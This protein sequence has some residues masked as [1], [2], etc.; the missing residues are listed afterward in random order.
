[1]IDKSLYN[2]IQK[3]YT[4]LF[5]IIV[6][7]I[8]LSIAAF[9]LSVSRKQFIL[10]SVSRDSTMAI[11]AA[12]SA[13]QCAVGAYYNGE[14]Y[15]SPDPATGDA[16][17]PA[18]IFCMGGTSSSNYQKID[19]AEYNLLIDEQ[20]KIYIY[21]TVTPFRF[22]FGNDSCAIVTITKGKDIATGKHRVFIESRGYNNEFSAPCNEGGAYNPRTV[23]RAIRLI[24]EDGNVIN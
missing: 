24:Y 7:S 9:I 13:I 18:R 19:S 22:G 14:L 3:G 4:L 15:A 10:S 23:E 2:R 17:S 16:T 11:Y 5:S 20:N 12:D 8:V 21:R 1:M 6:A